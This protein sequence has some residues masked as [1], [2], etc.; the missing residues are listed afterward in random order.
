MRLPRN[1][2]LRYVLNNEIHARP[3]EEFVA[4]TQ[5]TFAAVLYPPDSNG[6]AFRDLERLCEMTG[7]L[8]PRPDANHFRTDLGTIRLKWERHT[9][10]VT[11][12]FSR[13]A[14]FDEPFAKP[15][16]A[17]VPE[18][19]LA[20]IGGIMLV[21]IH[22]AVR[23]QRLLMPDLKDV[24]R[25]FS[26]NYLVGARVGGGRAIV[27]TDFRIHEDGFSRMLLMDV[28]LGK[29]QGGRM[30]QR[31]V[32]IETYRMLALLALPVAREA[33]AMLPDAERDLA[34]IT[35]SL[36]QAAPQDEPGLLDQLT[37]LAASVENQVSITSF[38]FGAARAYNALATRRIAELREERLV[39]VQTIDEFIGRRLAPAMNTCE[40]ASRRLMELSE[41]IARTSDLLRTRVDVER[42]QQNLALLASMDRRANLQLRLQQTVEGLSV[43]AITYYAVGLIV[44]LGEAVAALGVAVK[45]RVIA[46]LFIPIIAVGVWWGIRRLRRKLDETPPAKEVPE[47]ASRIHLKTKYEQVSS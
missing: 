34:A 45:P 20:N 42:E 5:I 12:T 26:G 41:R 10:F 31:L 43:A 3:P 37:R 8:P 39:G 25:Q 47:S 7:V 35:S 44:H 30:V 18:D 36:A 9:E 2:P 13:Q 19:W 40:S 17:Q 22:L 6:G 27:L 11:Y 4:P 46:G 21:A 29:R 28:G 15:V 14:E 1:H 16:I 33:A 38:R 23:D 24:A 32:E